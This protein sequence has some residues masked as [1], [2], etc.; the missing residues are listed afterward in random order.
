MPEDREWGAAGSP[1]WGPLRLWAALGP[2]EPAQCPRPAT[3]LWPSRA[4]L[5]IHSLWACPSFVAGSLSGTGPGLD[6][7]SPL[8][9]LPG[10]PHGLPKPRW[11]S[12]N[13]SQYLTPL[14]L[15]GAFL[16]VPSL[17]DPPEGT[18]GWTLVRKTA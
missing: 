12:A 4:S 2:R 5:R 18:F 16:C 10:G 14:V 15:T 13:K 8:R 1:G 7:G 17:S 9:G 6:A 11:S 3:S